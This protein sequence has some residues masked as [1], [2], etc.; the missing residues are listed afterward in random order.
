MNFRLF[1]L[2]WK[3]Y[4]C[5][6]VQTRINMFF[7]ISLPALGHI[8]QSHECISKFKVLVMN[9]YLIMHGGIYLIHWNKGLIHL[10]LQAVYIP[11]LN[12]RSGPLSVVLIPL[13]HC[14]WGADC[15]TG[16]MNGSVRSPVSLAYRVSVRMDS[17]NPPVLG[18]SKKS[19]SREIWRQI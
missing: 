1:S 17:Q 3:A 2:Q 8:M 6:G 4:I 15:S 16:A 18:R 11:N 19:C 5:N 14:V 12:A 7:F 13:T 10:H 9:V